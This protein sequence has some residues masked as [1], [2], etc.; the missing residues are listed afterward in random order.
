MSKDYA[1]NSLPTGQELQQALDTG[2]PLGIFIA[3]VVDGA[4]SRNKPTAHCVQFLVVSIEHED[5]ACMVQLLAKNGFFAGKT[6]SGKIGSSV[7]DSHLTL[8]D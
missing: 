5:G 2:T 6:Y 8:E 3:P 4:N 1:L 7:E